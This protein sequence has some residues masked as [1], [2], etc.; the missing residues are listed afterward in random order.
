MFMFDRNFEPP[1]R[2]DQTLDLI[3]AKSA[4]N[5]S[6]TVDYEVPGSRLN[7]TAVDPPPTDETLLSNYVKQLP[8]SVKWQNKPQSIKLTP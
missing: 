2:H 3:P 1:R 6:F 5:T 4:Q 7:S 8:T